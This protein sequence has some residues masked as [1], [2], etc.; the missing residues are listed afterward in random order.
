MTRYRYVAL[1]R[2]I[3]VGGHRVKMAH[4]RGLFDELRFDDVETLI[5]SGNVIFSADTSDVGALRDK[6]E[7]HLKRE[8]GYEVATFIRS[9][10]ELEE[11][12]AFEP[13]GHDV[14]EG[15]VSS[16]YVIF[17]AAN[18]T[19]DMR[20]GFAGLSS[21][22]DQFTISGRE[23]YWLIHGKMSESPLFATGLEKATGKVPTTTRNMTT[24]RRLVAKLGG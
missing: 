23:I 20:S 3:N 18:A 17:L 6:I 5:A 10:A 16:L 12:A 13:T 19:D 7:H 24:I 15:T 4:L 9:S 22:M 1:L 11:I 14:R 8:L 2:G 21:E